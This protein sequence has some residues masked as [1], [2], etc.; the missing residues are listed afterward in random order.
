MA[1]ARPSALLENDP[2]LV[3]GFMNQSG[4]SLTLGR[5][6]T[7]HGITSL[8][9]ITVLCSCYGSKVELPTPVAGLAHEVSVEVEREVV[10]FCS[11]CHVLPKPASFPKAAWYDEVKAGFEFY[12]ASGRNDMTPPAVQATVEY[13]QSRAPEKLNAPAKPSDSGAERRRFRADSSKW[14]HFTSRSNPPSISFL[15]A[16]K[17]DSQ[18]KP[19]IL[20]S[21]MAEGDVSLWNPLGPDSSPRTIGRLKNPAGACLCDLDG[22]GTL[23]IVVADLGS[24]SPADHDCGQVVWLPSVWDDSQDRSPHV[25]ARGLSRICDVQPADF[26]GDGDLDLAVAEFG[27]LKTGRT[28]WLQNDGPPSAPQFNLKVIDPRHGAIHTPI[29]DLNKDGRPDVVVLISQEFE[30]IVAFLNVGGGEF[31]KQTLHAAN[32]PSFGSSGMQVIDLDQDGDDD[33]LYTNGDMFDSQLVKPYHG[34]HWLENTGTFP[35]VAHTLTALPGVHRAL[36]GDLDNDGDLD[37]AA[38][39]FVPNGLRVNGVDRDL[40]AM[41]W[42]EQVRPGEF[43]RHAI[44][45]GGCLH[46]TCELADLDRDGDLDIVAGSFYE[47]GDVNQPAVT[48]W[49]NETN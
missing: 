19:S 9:A 16:V 7:R 12:R 47:R 29:V 13:F 48:V 30:T 10:R 1:A 20:I 6:V 35:F 2:S 38:V 37:I 3:G 45:T 22:N 14:P 25:I 8:F 4:S 24:R 31:E 17:G 18:S 15:K 27:W 46:A 23:D 11:L 21:D 36:A 5:R 28:L 41:I 49:W 42:L 39:A 32:D 44:E 26:D 40:D 33:V 43:Q 34:V